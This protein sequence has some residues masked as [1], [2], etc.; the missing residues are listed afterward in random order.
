MKYLKVEFEIHCSDDLRQVCR[1]LVS[2]SAGEA[3][4]ES[5]EDTEWGINGYIQKDT[6]SQEVLDQVLADFPIDNVAINYKVEDIEDENWNQEWE[7]V[8]FEPIAI[9]DKMVIFDARKTIPN[10]HFEIEIGIEAKNAFGTGSH[11]TTH[12]ILQQLLH[13]PVEG[14]RIL[15]CGCGTGILSIAASR[16]GADEI[17]A[18]DIDDWSV[19]NTEHNAMLNGVSNI[20]VLEGDASVLSHISGVFDVVLANINRNILLNDMHAFCDVL[21]IGG[22][23]I[24]SGFYEA[25]APLLLEKASEFGL[26]EVARHTN[27]NWC[28]LALQ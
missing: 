4:F 19:R 23:L 11:Q 28:L 2:A 1:E 13:T 27:D 25:D 24:L 12:M 10:F 7:A 9:E 17:I 14:K 3:G 8:G 5:F 15:D 6:Y 20:H 21:N 22:T 26:R 18:Y 16:L